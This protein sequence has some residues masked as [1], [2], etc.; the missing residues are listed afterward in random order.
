[1][2]KTLLTLVGLLVG[3][4]S[5]LSQ[6]VDIS[7]TT[8]VQRAESIDQRQQMRQSSIFQEYP[9]RNVGP[10]VMGGRVTDIAVHNDN[11][12]KFYV[13]YASGGVFKTENSGNSMEPIF[14]HQG[15]L[16]I[17]DIAISK[18]NKNVLWV[19]TGEN[20]SSRS[21][22]AGT[23]VYKS[24]DGGQSWSFAGLRGSQHIGRIVTHP[25]NP[26]VAWVASM[27]PLYSMNEV[28]GVYKTTDGGE[29]W[30][31]TLTPPDSSGVIDLVQHPE[32]PDKLWATTWQRYRQAWNFKEAGEGSAIYVSNDGGESWEKS[33][34]GFPDGKF[35]G[36]IGIDVSQSN[37]D[38]MYAFLDNQKETKT[39]RDIDD[40]KLIKNDFVDMSREEFLDLDNEKLNNFLR[41][42]G[43]QE[44]YT[45]EKVKEDVRDGRYNP[46]ALADYLGDANDALFETSIEGAQV[47]RS[48]NGGESW[49]KV[50]SY[51]LESLIYTYGYY[52]GEVRVSPSDPNTLYIM[53]VPM[54][55]S[56]DGGKTWK[57]VAEKQDVHVDHHAMWIDPNDSEHLLLGNDGGLYESHDGAINFIHHNV[58]PVGQFYTVAVDMEKPYNIYGGL[59][60]NGVYTGSSQ[61]SPNDGQQWKKI[62]GGDGMHV[63]VHPENSDLIYTGYQFGN[64]FR[65][66]QEEN[67]LTSITP[68]HDIGEAPYRFNWNTP[69]EMSNHN[70]EILYFG[71][72]KINRTMDGGETWTTI[73]P[74]LTKD[75]PNGDVPYS[76]LTT[77][78]ESPLDFSVIWAGTDDGNI[79]VTRDGGKSWELV[80]QNLPNRRWVSEV[81]ASPHDPATAYATLNGYRYDEFKTYI[82]KTDNYGKTWTPIKGNLP[83]DVANVVAQD[84]VNP[85]ILYAG[86]DHGTYVSFDDGSEWFLLNG[87]PNVASYD[88][89]VHP[90]DHELVVG[91]HGRSIYVA[92]LKPLRKVADNRDQTIMALQ[93]GAVRYSDDWGKRS[94]PYREIDEPNVEWMYWIG[95]EDLQDEKISITIEDKE[96]KV[97]KELSDQANYGFNILNWNL[98]VEENQEDDERTYLE[99]G[100]YTIIYKI[101]GSTDET[102]FDVTSRDNHGDA[103]QR[104]FSSP[105]EIEYEEY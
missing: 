73:S 98:L 37:P 103:E 41:S 94:A 56:T 58:A 88:M 34:K 97:V 50:N 59:Q 75:L 57:A 24:E 47:Y 54:L 61:G 66:N 13:A 53:G 102:T 64:Y 19:G 17:G 87:I 99:P 8:A 101:N 16:T 83:E 3:F 95:N 27:G 82:Y 5:V 4:S 90:R 60:D 9:V 70:P 10:V 43:F 65:I 6:E 92:D 63:A 71:S 72:Q 32:N 31:K 89:V 38:V 85:D 69:V 96:G 14:D 23:G 44:K 93:T 49:E 104:V 11:P 100:T 86:L 7:A 20:N 67:K 21:S 76:T 12:R 78:S 26:D 36:R 80:S 40:D 91:T 74:D 105:E 77:I 28:R 18:A 42:N 25:T 62:F 1:M 46:K 84:P 2:K 48:E 33:M 45:A 51:A 68:D 52:F 81:Q 15:T 55:K 35:V 22:Y 39:K 30:N 79:Q 29:S